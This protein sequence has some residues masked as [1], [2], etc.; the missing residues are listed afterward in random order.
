MTLPM[1]P[2]AIAAWLVDNT[3]LTFEQIAEFCGLH[4][5]EIQA[6][7]DGEAKGI[8]PMS[9]VIYHQLTKEE[10]ERCEKDTKAKL[11]LTQSAQ[12]IRKVKRTESY[13]P[14]SQRQNK[15]SGIL[16]IV[17]NHPELSDAQV[18]KLMHSTKKTIEDI[19]NGTHRLSSTV[20]P[21]NPIT[22]GIL[23]E[24]EFYRV[25]EKAQKKLNK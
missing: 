10:I 13:V 14:M 7:A 8:R 24:V 15:P 2:K 9:P 4:E 17:R 22:L 23:D 20:R 16:W 25:L 18:G 3:S 19:R 6:I 5:L 11:S 1:M 12:D 21:Q